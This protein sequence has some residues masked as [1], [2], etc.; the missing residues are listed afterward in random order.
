MLDASIPEWHHD[1][2][3]YDGNVDSISKVLQH[4]SRIVVHH[5]VIC[6]QEKLGSGSHSRED[7]RQSLKFHLSCT[8]TST[9]N[10]VQLR[11]ILQSLPFPSRPTML[12]LQ[13]VIVGIQQASEVHHD[14][15]FQVMT[16]RLFFEMPVEVTFLSKRLPAGGN[17]SWK[18]II[19]MQ[20]MKSKAR[21]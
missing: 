16:S 13:N 14:P 9:S 19:S 5:A 2:H 12:G 1:I 6:H 8:T 4:W 15:P 11:Q 18:T 3:A 21:K 17:T 10:S 7:P 20:T